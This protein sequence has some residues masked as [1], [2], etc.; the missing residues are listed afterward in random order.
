M[1]CFLHRLLSYQCT[2]IKSIRDYAT[3]R[4]IRAAC[5]GPCSRSPAVTL[6]SEACARG[7]ECTARAPPGGGPGRAPAVARVMHV[8]ARSAGAAVAGSAIIVD[9]TS[10]RS[11][12][13]QRAA[14]RAPHRTPRAARRTQHCARSRPPKSHDGQVSPSLC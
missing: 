1:L 9:T 13:T 12:L 4:G 6:H 2:R 5:G 10:L 11:P 14:R 8:A 7:A 3:G